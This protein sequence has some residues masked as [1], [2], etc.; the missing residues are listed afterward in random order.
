[1]Q[2]RPAVLE[3][4]ANRYPE[5][6]G[7]G[8]MGRAGSRENLP[9]AVLVEDEDDDDDDDDDDDHG[10]DHEPSI[11]YNKDGKRRS[12]CA[13]IVLESQDDVSEMK[14]TEDEKMRILEILQ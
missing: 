6:A 14:K 13:E 10:D 9:S 1:M 8:Q 3:Y 7:R 11:P 12:I 2:S 5:Q 4:S